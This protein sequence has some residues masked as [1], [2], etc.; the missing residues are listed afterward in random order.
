MT[1]LGKDRLFLRQWVGEKVKVTTVGQ[2]KFSGRLTKIV[3]DQTN[4]LTY[5]MLDD[6]HCVNFDY[7][8]SI[9]WHNQ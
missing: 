3:F 8:I 2:D 4:R 6:K 1:N 9:N 7:V 5:I